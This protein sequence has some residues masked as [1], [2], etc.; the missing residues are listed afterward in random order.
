MKTREI[1][2]EIPEITEIVVIE[3][4]DANG[5]FFSKSMAIIELL[6]EDKKVEKEEKTE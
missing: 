2:I 4:Y 3:C 6:E 5:S 1:V